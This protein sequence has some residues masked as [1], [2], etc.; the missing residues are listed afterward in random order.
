M[1]LITQYKLIKLIK[2]IDQECLI[3]NLIQITNRQN[4]Q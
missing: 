3:Y 2:H 4:D 1:Y